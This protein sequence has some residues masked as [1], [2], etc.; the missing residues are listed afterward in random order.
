MLQEAVDHPDGK[1]ARDIA[2]TIFGFLIPLRNLSIQNIARKGK[3]GPRFPSE[4]CWVTSGDYS[5]HYACNRGQ[6]RK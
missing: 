1:P 4:T 2:I 6:A 3:A 5:S